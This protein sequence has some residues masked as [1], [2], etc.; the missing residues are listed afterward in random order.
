MRTAPAVERGVAV[1]V[2]ARA[3]RRDSIAKA[4]CLREIKRCG[5]RKLKRG[6]KV[7]ERSSTYAQ[8][9][10]RVLGAESCGSS[11]E[12]RSGTIVS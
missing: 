11:S 12:T 1:A 10:N 3:R 6:R 4:Y 8:S 2:A 5:D 7:E 9:K